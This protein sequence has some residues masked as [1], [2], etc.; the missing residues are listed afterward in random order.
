M[1]SQVRSVGRPSDDELM[2]WPELISKKSVRARN[3]GHATLVWDHPL[4]ETANLGSIKRPK[5]QGHRLQGR[6]NRVAPHIVRKPKLALGGCSSAAVGRNRFSAAGNH[7]L[8]A[9][10]WN[11]KLAKTAIGWSL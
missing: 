5:L 7:P 2:S 3:S 4:A 8:A 9:H 11:H 1:L 6:S 10:C